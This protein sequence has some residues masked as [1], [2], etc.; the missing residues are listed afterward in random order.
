MLPVCSICKR[1]QTREEAKYCDYCGMETIR[2]ESLEE[3][4]Q[5]ID[6]EKALQKE[7]LIKSENISVNTMAT[8]SDTRKFEV[9]GLVFGTSSKLA[10]WGLSTQAD[11]LTRAYSAALASLKYEAALLGADAVLGVNFALNNSTGSAVLNTGSS[12]AVMLLGT[13]VRYI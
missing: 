11:R 5:K 12:E 9:L 10:F 7:A 1:E 2:G 4:K 13:A 3:F 8:P 6:D